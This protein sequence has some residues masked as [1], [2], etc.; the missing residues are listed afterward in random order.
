M[1]KN[2]NQRMESQ[3]KGM[4][5]RENFDV[6]EAQSNDQGATLIIRNIL[7]DST[8]QYIEVCMLSRTV[9]YEIEICTPIKTS[10]NV[11]YY[12]IL[13]SPGMGKMWLLRDN[14]LEKLRGD[15][16]DARDSSPYLVKNFAR[17]KTPQ[18]NLEEFKGL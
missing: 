10:E 6:F 4:L 16:M 18:L 7:E 14:E 8:P 12:Y 17:L 15:G 1:I 5:A 9:E 13:H 2:S 3:I 11:Y